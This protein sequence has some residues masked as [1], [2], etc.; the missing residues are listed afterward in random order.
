MNGITLRPARQED[1]SIAATLL[2]LSLGKVG[3]YLFGEQPDLAERALRRLFLCDAGRFGFRQ[4][5]IAERAGQPLGMA[6]AFPGR[7]ALR[8][9]LSVARHLPHA[10]G[11]RVFDFVRRG[12]SLVKGP[13][14]LSDEYYLSNLAVLPEAQRQG[15]GTCLLQHV[16]HL[17]WNG[18]LPK[19]SLL[20]G[21]EN[22]AA[23]RL[24]LRHGFQIVQ[25]HSDANPILAYHRLVKFLSLPQ[26]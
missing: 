21:M 7:L 3:T 4:A 16:E 24:Y 8:L 6:V 26:I 13:E 12:L 19:V 9:S 5:W 1:A 11:R 25:T 2:R 20:V 18:S 23:L 15:I 10:L 22:Q 17:A 14:C